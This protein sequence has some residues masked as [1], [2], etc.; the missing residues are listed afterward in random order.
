[1]RIVFLGTPDFALPSLMQL[2]REG[3]EIVG[4]F[5]QPDKPVGRKQLLQ[6]PPVKRVAESLGLPVFQ[7]DR[8]RGTEGVSALRSLRPD[9]LITAAFGQILSQEIL[10]IPPLGCINVHGSLLPAYRGAAPIQWA[11][12]DGLET[13]GV[14]TMR[15]EK[16]IDTGDMLIQKSLAIGIDETAGELFVRVAE[17]GAEALSE[18]LAALERDELTRT[19]QD[20]TL[21]THCRMLTKADGIIDWSADARAIHNRV[22]GVNPWPGATAKLRGEPIKIWK[23]RLLLPEETDAHAEEP[24]TVIAAQPGKLVV[25]AGNGAIAIEVLQT[26]GGKPLAVADYLRG[27]PIRE[28]ERFS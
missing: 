11:V 9:C 25:A 10:D 3:R 26:T 6:A 16:G 1:M 24:G 23:T 13:T 27:H 18:T 19:P 28:G 20:D 8:I 21:A 12:I 7:F 15:T 4:V 2:A 5:T 17:L 14:T 22:R